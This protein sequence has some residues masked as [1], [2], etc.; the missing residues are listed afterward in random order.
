MGTHG[1]HRPWS[2]RSLSSGPN[3]PEAPPTCK[4]AY[5]PYPQSRG[6]RKTSDDLIWTPEDLSGL[7][8]GAASRS[9]DRG[10]LFVITEG[11][12]PNL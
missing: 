12:L 6:P 1:P 5:R 2:R 7:W 10:I 9:K 8:C 4:W 3:L 11:N